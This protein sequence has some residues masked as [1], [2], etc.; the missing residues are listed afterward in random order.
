M[1]RANR[2]LRERLDSMI[3][4]ECLWEPVAH[5]WSVR[6]RETATSSHPLGGATGFSTSPWVVV[7]N[8]ITEAIHHG[9]EIGVLRDLYTQEV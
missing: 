8:V 1:E 9:A 3:D 7:T 6:R 5:S 2:R 4:D